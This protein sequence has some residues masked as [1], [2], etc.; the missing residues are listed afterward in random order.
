MS[1]DRANAIGRAR[2][3]LGGDLVVL[4]TETTGTG[5]TDEIV[6]IAVISATG[7]P[8]LESLV[9]PNRPIPKEATRIHG[10]TDADV[11][12]APTILELLVDLRGILEGRVVTAYNLDFDARLLNSSLQAWGAKWPYPG[13]GHNESWIESACIMQLYAEFWGAWS[14]YHKSFT[15]Q[16]LDRAL[17]QCGLHM[18][19]PLH[20]AMTDAQAALAVLEHVA[21]TPLP[22]NSTESILQ[23]KG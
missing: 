11:Q 14:H 23:E 15:W 3:I 6:E 2:E 21:G 1:S 20:R 16:A 4:D 17:F 12:S 5:A 22:G 13:R 18:E 7:T 10:I 8:L 19:G 9:R